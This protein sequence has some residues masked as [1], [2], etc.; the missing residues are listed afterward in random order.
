M[1][2]VNAHCI[3]IEACTCSVWCHF[4]F[5]E[6][7]NTI[8]HEFVAIAMVVSNVGISESY[9][10]E[11]CSEFCTLCLTAFLAYSKA[12]FNRPKFYVCQA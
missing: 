3:N 11:S 8:S 12:Y 1:A 6:A 5:N 7:K 4:R 9:Y 10:S 2:S